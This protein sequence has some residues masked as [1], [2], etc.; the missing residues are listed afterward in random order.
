MH[1]KHHATMH[2]PMGPTTSESTVV[3]ISLMKPILFLLLLLSC[4]FFFLH[5][6]VNVTVK[7]LNLDHNDISDKGTCALAN[8]LKANPSS[9]VTEVNLSRNEINDEGA[10]AFAGR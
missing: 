1:S 8:A 9:K 6:K 3:A 10:L 4:L 7:T 5:Q 2:H